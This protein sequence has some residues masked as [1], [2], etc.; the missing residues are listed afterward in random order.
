MQYA[1]TADIGHY[2]ER[3]ESTHAVESAVIP[4][5]DIPVLV[6]GLYHLGIPSFFEGERVYYCHGV[7][8]SE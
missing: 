5:V 1:G 7:T 3:L 4:N 6:P 8:R 2:N